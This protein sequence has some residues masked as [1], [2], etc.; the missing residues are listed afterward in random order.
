MESRSP[1][2]PAARRPAIRFGVAPLPPGF[3]PGGFRCER[4]EDLK[5][6]EVDEIG[7]YLAE[8]DAARD[9]A[10]GFSRTFLVIEDG[11]D[12]LLGYYTLLADAVVLDA[13]EHLEGWAYRS[14]PAVKIARLGVHC[15]LQGYGIGVQVFDYILGAVYGLAEQL[16]VRFITLDAVRAKIPWYENRGFRFTTITEQPATEADHAAGDRSMFYDLGPVAS[17]PTPVVEGA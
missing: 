9:Q 5:E 3:A 8:G 12:R 1:E 10:V 14:V 6:G 17:R 2:P 16:G 11:T 4:P 7:T 15:D 13:D